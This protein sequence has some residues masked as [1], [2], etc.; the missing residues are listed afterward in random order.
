MWDEVPQRM[1]NGLQYSIQDQ[2]FLRSY[3]SAPRQPP[4]P[5]S[6]GSKLSLLLSLPVCRWSSL[7]TGERVKGVGVEPNLTT[8]RNH[9]P[10]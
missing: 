5:L 3:D 1:S 7:L 2:A 10:L 9:G 4:S 8:T 6:R